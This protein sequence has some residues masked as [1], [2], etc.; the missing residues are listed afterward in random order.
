MRVLKPAKIVN[1]VH[2]TLVDCT[3]RDL[4]EQ[5]ATI[6]CGDQIAVPNEFRLLIPSENSI[7]NAKVTW[8][9]DSHIGMEFYGEKMRAPARKI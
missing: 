6:T 8:R 3:L 4:T 2:W 1:L 9:K 7:Q 5:G